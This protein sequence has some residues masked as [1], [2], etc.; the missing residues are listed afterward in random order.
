MKKSALIQ[1]IVISAILSALAIMKYM[2]LGRNQVDT[3]KERYERVLSQDRKILKSRNA[4]DADVNSAL[5]RLGS[6][7]ELFARSE[8]LKRI[9]SESKLV[10]AGVGNA[11]GFFDDEEARS[12]VKLLL[13][14]REVS[15]RIQ[16]ISGLGHRN[17]LVRERLIAEVLKRVGLTE[18]ERQAAFSVLAR[19]AQSKESREYAVRELLTATLKASTPRARVAT[20]IQVLTVAPRDPRV[21]EMLE[22]ILKAGNTPD[23][24]SSAIRHLAVAK[25]PWLKGNLTQLS[26]SQNPQTRLAVVQSLH[27]LCPPDRFNILQRAFEKDTDINVRSAALAEQNLM[28]SSGPGMGHD[29][30]KSAIK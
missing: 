26:R 23:L 3:E 17:S 15:V 30:C 10:R 2:D 13:G 27:I 7:N 12:A 6:E 11:L 14:D 8:S 18:E 9:R 1:G 25:N 24:E 20:A 21:L 16:A 4:S 5:I 28:L 29:F 22:E 19:I